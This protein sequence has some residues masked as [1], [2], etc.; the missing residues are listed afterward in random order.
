[1]AVL[2]KFQT[3]KTYNRSV[4]PNFYVDPNTQ[5]LNENVPEG[6]TFPALSSVPKQYLRDPNE[7][8][9]TDKSPIDWTIASE[10][11]GNDISTDERNQRAL[12]RDFLAQKYGQAADTKGVEEALAK[13]KSENQW[14]DAGYNVDRMLMAHSAARGGPGAD[15]G[16]WEG[17]KKAAA[18]EV[19]TQEGLRQAKIKD[20][21]AKKNLGEEGVKELQQMHGY[22]ITNAQNDPHSNISRS[23]QNA[24]GAMFPKEAEQMGGDIPNMSATEIAGIAKMYGAKAEAELRRNIEMAKL[25][26]A[27]AGLQLQERKIGN[28]EAKA[29]RE[30]AQLAP[31]TQAEIDKIK[32]D[33][34]LTQARTKAVQAGKPGAAPIIGNEKLPA[35]ANVPSSVLTKALTEKKAADEFDK[36]KDQ[37][38]KAY[39]G[40]GKFGFIEGNVPSYVELF[41]K[42]GKKSEYEAYV[43]QVGT[44]IVAKVPGIRSDNDYKTFVKPM[45]PSPGDPEETIKMKSALFKKW[46]ESQKPETPTFNILPDA[47]KQKFGGASAYKGR[48]VKQGGVLYEWD[49]QGYQES[50]GGK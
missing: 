42:K 9:P 2:D 1:M 38:I 23:Y 28:E 46:I 31:K 14:A 21:L 39:E 30:T 5:Y 45:L 25:G 47:I 13:Q 8:L 7:V 22:D 49:G 6:M 15:R 24:F 36:V 18:S 29:G 34:A 11:N 44:Q 41:G 35:D 43:A 12:V 26:Y 37:A 19:E 48:F 40:G 10:S 33:I 32:A 3:K 4:D 20:Y 17:Q 27:D 16:Y 50:I